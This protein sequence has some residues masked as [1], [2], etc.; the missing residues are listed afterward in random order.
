MTARRLAAAA[1]VAGALTPAE[2]FRVIATRSQ[3]MSRR[4]ATGAI[5]LLELDAVATEALISDFPDVTVAV[6]AS[7]RQTVVAGPTLPAWSQ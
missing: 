5:A 1:V 2:G 3:L 6:Y 7:P 4:A